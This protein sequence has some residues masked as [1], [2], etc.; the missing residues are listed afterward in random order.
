MSEP[1]R[2]PAHFTVHVEIDGGFAAIPGLNRPFE[3]DSSQLEPAEAAVLDTVLTELGFFDLST[4]SVAPRP[5]AADYR[6][7]TIT[8][9]R[10]GRS[11][12]ARFVEPIPDPKLQQL[13]DRL[14]AWHRAH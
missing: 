14:L 10:G 2:S 11:H 5:G 12:T 3:V 13:V 1:R 6:S 4:A 7:Y 9:S 8:V